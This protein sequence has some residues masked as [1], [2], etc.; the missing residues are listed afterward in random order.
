MR[1][2]ALIPMVLL[3]TSAVAEPLTYAFDKA[4]SQI[5]ASVNHLGFSNSTA[6]FLIKDGSLTLDVAEPTSG[7]VDVTIDANSMD[8]GDAKWKEHLSTDKWFNLAA[9]PDIRFVSTKVTSTGN[10]TMSIEGNLTLLGVTKP[11]TLNARLN[12]AGEHPFSKKPAV[13]FSATAN[14]KRSE[15][16]MDAYVPNVG[17]EVSLRIEIEASAG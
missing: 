8:F 13:G 11:V 9:F 6:R 17:D 15:F 14:F 2:F 4:H 7:K 5:H 3:S 12:K 16:G 1:K 10:D